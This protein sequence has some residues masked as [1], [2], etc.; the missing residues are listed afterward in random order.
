MTGGSR[1]ATTA[2]FLSFLWPGLGQAYARRPRRAIAFAI[3]PLLL[4]VVVGWVAL[5]DPAA[6]ALNLLG[7]AAAAIAVAV[8]ALHGMWRVAAITDA[9]RLASPRTSAA[10]PRS[11]LTAAFLSLLVVLAHLWAGAFVQ[12]FANAGGAIF[13]GVRPAGQSALDELLGGDSETAHAS[14]EASLGEADSDG[15]GRIDGDMDGDGS[16]NSSDDL[17][18]DGAIDGDDIDIADINGDGVINA[19]DKTGDGILDGDINGDG[20]VD[21]RDVDEPNGSPAPSFDP[22][23]TPPPVSASP[24]PAEP[25]TPPPQAGDGPVNVLF[26]G[27]DGSSTRRHSLSD[28]LIVASYYPSRDKVTMISIPRDTGRLPLY[29]GGVYGNRINSFLGYARR[30]PELFPEG[31]IAALMREIGYV[32][33]INIPYYAATNLDGLPRAVDL[34]GG[35]D[36]VLDKA[37]ADSRYPLYLEPGPYHLDGESVMPYV[38][39]RYGPNNSDWQRARRQQQVIKALAERVRDPAV[40]LRLPELIDA[41][42]DVVRT[43]VPRDQANQLLRIVERAN[44]ASTEHIV[45]SPNQYA[46]RIPPAEVN[47]RSMTELNIA[48]IRQLSLRVFGPHSRYR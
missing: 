1:S 37:I 40:A 19:K 32:L 45:L 11:F 30:H 43:N 21:D 2:S 28:T 46:R 20:V 47:G 6:F 29:K 33:G 42:S 41:L 10:S 24:D 13:T 15:D 31:P 39:S 14:P 23:L 5:S 8:L 9:W 48:A 22:S 12:S 44:D 3:P 25:T 18:G 36:V 4:L 35:V 17:N 26:V 7:S 27:L 34:V 16:V 38:R